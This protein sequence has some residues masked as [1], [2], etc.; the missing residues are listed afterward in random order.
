MDWLITQD[1]FCP[2]LQGRCDI[3]PEVEF[4]K[5]ISVMGLTW[6]ENRIRQECG[7]VILPEDLG[8]N[9]DYDGEFFTLRVDLF[10][11]ATAISVNVG[12]N[13]HSSTLESAGDQLPF[14]EGYGMQPM[15]NPR[16]P[17]MKVL[18]CIFK[19]NN[20]EVYD[21][22]GYYYDDF[23][24]LNVTDPDYI[25]C[26]IKQGPGF[27]L[28]VMMPW[29]QRCQSCSMNGSIPRYCDVIDIYTVMLFFDNGYDLVETLT[30]Y[31]HQ[32]ITTLA[33]A[34]SDYV[35][36]GEFYCPYDPNF[37][38]FC[39][40]CT[41][42]NI[43]TYDSDDAYVNSYKFELF[44]GHCY[45]S[46]SSSNFL[47]LGKAPPTPLT[48]PYYRCTSPP[49]SALFNALGIAMGNMDL[50]AP[51]LLVLTL[52]M[53]FIYQILIGKPPEKPESSEHDVD[54]DLKRFAKLLHSALD[55][56]ENQK[57]PEDSVLHRLA[58]ELKKYDGRNGKLKKSAVKLK[59]ARM[60]IRSASKLF[61]RKIP[62]DPESK[63]T[64]TTARGGPDKAQLKDLENL[65]DVP[66]SSLSRE[67]SKQLSRESSKQL[68]E[69]LLASS[70]PNEYHND[71]VQ[72]VSKYHAHLEKIDS[73]TLSVGARSI[74]HVAKKGNSED[75]TTEAV[76]M[77][78]VNSSHNDY[79]EHFP[80]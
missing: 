52:P 56:P 40:N 43:E 6:N 15:Y 1:L 28:P 65:S 29:D 27:S 25:G 45:D 2:L 19:A 38:S 66:I 14:I 39:K 41:L 73:G 75:K 58:M 16:H 53:I 67:S 68:P 62:I 23:T 17:G 78:S 30:N 69:E 64:E 59:N 36:W 26:V 31:T 37:F 8:Y 32:E 57:Y 21:Q 48:E 80:L 50:F 4:D 77:N 79:D 7:N 74:H 49:W 47:M 60:L 72:R 13:S 54:V 71:G 51:C 35:M 24:P 18:W 9:P 46:I 33:Y 70:L 63:D 61:G 76:S 10:T 11:V 3:R 42:Y 34:A 44:A 20:S 22:G 55:D 5:T 12:I